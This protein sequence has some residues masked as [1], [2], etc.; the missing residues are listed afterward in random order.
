MPSLGVWPPYTLFSS[1]AKIMRVSTVLV[2]QG[3]EMSHQGYSTWQSISIMQAH[4]RL[5][6]SQ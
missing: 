5:A 1:S 3:N 2:T 6:E 4:K